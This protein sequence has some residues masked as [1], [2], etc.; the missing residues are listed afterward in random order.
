MARCAH[1]ERDDT[2]TI[3]AEN[4]TVLR[5]GRREVLRGASCGFE[6]GRLTGIIGPNGAGKSTLLKALAGLLKPASGRILLD[7]RDTAATTR[8]AVAKAI[9]YLPQERTIHWPLTVSRVVALGRTP[10]RQGFSA[11]ETEHDR[12]AIERAIET[13]DI[14]H[15]RARP[16]DEISG[17]ELARVL[18]ARALAQETPVILADEP[19]SGLDPLHALQLFEALRRLAGSGKTIVVALHDLTLAARF[20]HDVV[21]IA[22]GRVVASGPTR[23]TLS[24]DRL[25][26]AFGVRF[27]QG[28]VEGIPIVLPAA[29]LP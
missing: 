29:P 6:S 16:A 9:A 3:M 8:D 2:V 18:M 15:L 24:G 11:A 13:M 4:I 25:A 20:C 28:S 7:G 12:A 14:G 19:T 5:H 10:H 1:A 21:V 22:D 23:E 27:A 17:G 26:E